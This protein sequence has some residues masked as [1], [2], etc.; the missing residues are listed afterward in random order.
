MEIFLNIDLSHEAYFRDRST[1]SQMVAWNFSEFVTGLRTLGA[2]LLQMSY[3]EGRLCSHF[4]RI[5][6][7]TTSA[8]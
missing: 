4:S 2:S 6:K 8:D 7:C 1:L 5:D 3:L